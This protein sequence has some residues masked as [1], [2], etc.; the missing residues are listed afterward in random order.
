ML[1]NVFILMRFSSLSFLCSRLI[2]IAHLLLIFDMIIHSNRNRSGE[3]K[4][5]RYLKYR[6][7][8]FLHILWAFQVDRPLRYFVYSD[9]QE[10][11]SCHLDYIIAILA[12]LHVEY[13]LLSY[14]IYES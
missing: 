12:G 13:I 4:V 5:N 9:H 7:K 10:A 1:H 11:S 6:P 3:L 8:I 2:I 14:K